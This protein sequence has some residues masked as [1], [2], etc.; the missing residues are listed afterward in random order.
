MINLS[1]HEEKR[2][3]GSQGEHIVNILTKGR[4]VV[5]SRRVSCVGALSELSRGDFPGLVYSRTC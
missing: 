5:F 3:G 4:F 1:N 2:R